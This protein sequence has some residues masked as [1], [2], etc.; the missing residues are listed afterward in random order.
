MM[1]MRTKFNDNRVTLAIDKLEVVFPIVTTDLTN[2]NDLLFARANAEELTPNYGKWDG[3]PCKYWFMQYVG[4]GLKVTAVV[5]KLS[6]TSLFEL[7]KNLLS[8]DTASDG[9]T[10][11]RT[12][13]DF[14]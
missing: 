5:I 12:I 8:F 10:E 11:I 2:L 7:P 9:V 6:Q 13:V 4:D 14:I 1:Q 3:T